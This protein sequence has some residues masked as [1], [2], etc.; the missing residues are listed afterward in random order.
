MKNCVNLFGL[1]ADGLRTI[2]T[3]SP[4]VG[5]AAVDDGGLLVNGLMDLR[6]I[7]TNFLRLCQMN[8]GYKQLSS[9]M[10]SLRGRVALKSRNILL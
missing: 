10:V 4:T 3:F 9:V 5:E 2:S 1:E 7:I 6:D 8:A